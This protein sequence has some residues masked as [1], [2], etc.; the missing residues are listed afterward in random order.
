MA[1]AWMSKEGILSKETN[2]TRYFFHTNN[3][4]SGLKR[5]KLAGK[6]LYKYSYRISERYFKNKLKQGKWIKI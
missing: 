4:K 6:P 3:R 2:P 1:T 5:V